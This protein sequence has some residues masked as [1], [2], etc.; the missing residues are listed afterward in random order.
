MM[1]R[2]Y[3]MMLS[4]LFFGTT[5]AQNYNVTFQV[6]LGSATPNANGIHVAGDFQNPVWTPDGTQMTQVGTSSIYEVTVSL[7]AGNYEFKFLNGDAWGDD[8][9]PPTE[10]AVSTS[11]S[12]R[13]VSVWSDTTLP[14]VLFGECAPAGMN[15]I[16]MMVDMSQE[17]TINDT[18]SVA[19]NFQGWSPG[20]TIMTDFAGDSVY[21]T[22]AYVMSGDTVQYKYING[23]AWGADESVPGACANSGGNREVIA[24]SNLIA[25]P[26]C[27]ASCGPCF[28]PDTFNVTIQVDLQNVCDTI[29]YVD[30]A[31]PLNGW[32]G[33]DTLTYNASTG[34]YEGTFY[35]PAPSFK[36]K[37]RYFT[38]SGSGANWEGGGDKEPTFSSDT[39]L[40]ARCFGSDNYG[41]CTPKPAPADITFRVDFAQ[42]GIT[43]AAEIYL[44]ADFTQWQTNAILMTPMTTN[45]GVYETVVQDLCPAE[46]FF[47]F[48]N[49]DVSIT[50][51]EEGDKLDS[52]GVPSGTGSFNRYFLRPDANPHTL[53]FIFDSCQA[54]FIG[55]DENDLAEEVK[56]SPNPFST[57]ATIELGDDNYDVTI[58]DITG[59][60]VRQM[61]GATGN[62]V[63]ERGNMKAGIYMMTVVNTKGEARTSKFVVE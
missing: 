18:V 36:Y 56:I 17:A 33:G 10:C 46:L 15:S 5:F 32:A 23:A 60:I 9:T 55:L 53:Q 43:P 7:A 38:A 34:Y 6:D 27:F 42:S 39:T 35:M 19:G 2:I 59:R 12:N 11:N 28:V 24:S 1:K 22:M 54:I 8:E 20:A 61:T 40:P 37:A 57:S 16:M 26:V 63:I 52:C 29:D 44:I 31:G 3:L 14:A 50:S 13:W 45:P 48:V 25:G 4:V 58:M 41:P 49:G 21:R 47:K 62:V 51:N 30:I